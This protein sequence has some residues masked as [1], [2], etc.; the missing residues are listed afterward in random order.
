MAAKRSYAC[1]RVATPP[2]G[3]VAAKRS[4]PTSKEPRLH[5]HR[6]SRRSY[7]TFKVRSGG[8]EKIPLVQGKG[9][10]LSFAGVAMKRYPTSE[11][12]ESQV[13]W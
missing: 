1:L 9:Q 13:R 10:G 6:R 7:S 2:A 4:N 5:G 11:V 3:G 8:R 12:R